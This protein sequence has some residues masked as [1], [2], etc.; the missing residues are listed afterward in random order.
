MSL[1]ALREPTIPSP[2]D[3]APFLRRMPGVTLGRSEGLGND[4]PRSLPLRFGTLDEVLPDGGLPRGAVVEIAAPY[5]L[6]RATSI[7]LAA[8]ASAQAEA[9]LR[10]GEGTAGAWCA[11]IEPAAREA[12]PT[13]FAPAAARAGVDLSRLLVIR[14]PM[15]AL[16][17]AAARAAESRVFSVIVI[18]LTGVPG[19]R[20]EARLDRWVN[21]VRR[22]AMA[23]S[24]IEA[25]VVLLTDALAPRPLPLPVALRLEVERATADRLS[26]TVAKDR[27][28]RVAA[29]KTVI[30][31][32]DKDTSGAPDR[33]EQ[34]TDQR[35]PIAGLA[36]ARPAGARG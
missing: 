13:L 8:C 23:A 22:L 31:P 30:L 18:D 7:A 19:K 24:E 4:G 17:R 33:A 20:A 1:A 35:S 26:V 14:P 34:P 6:A 28:G 9:K 25:T 16:A 15:E 2:P 21:P 36:K 29:P 10:G 27:R 5:G 12:V 32:R 3:S 11:W